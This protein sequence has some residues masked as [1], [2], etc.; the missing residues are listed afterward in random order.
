MNILKR[1]ISYWFFIIIF[2]MF[3]ISLILVNNAKP[4][5]VDPQQFQ[6]DLQQ[7]NPLECTMNQMADPNNKDPLYKKAIHAAKSFSIQ[8][9]T[10]ITRTVVPS[11]DI[12]DQI[13]NISNETKIASLIQIP[14]PM[15]GSAII[16]TLTDGQQY[17]CNSILP[18]D[19]Q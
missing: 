7:G 19:A 5:T 11:V 2:I 18:K 3:C 17:Y 14:S 4:N 16:A 12:T 9:P 6:I 15:P 8:W 10:S 13:T 1:I